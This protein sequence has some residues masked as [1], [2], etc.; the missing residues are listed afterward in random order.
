MPQSLAMVLVHI[1]FSTKERVPCIVREVRP[2]LNAYLAGI[3]RNL[4]CIP[5]EVNSMVDHVHIFCNL[6]RTVAVASLVEEFKKGSS[7]WI[8]PK[9]GAVMRNFHWQGG[10]GA[11]SVS[12]SMVPRVRR[13]ILDQEGHHQKVTF[14]E[15]FRAFLERH[16]ERH[17]VAYD[18]RYVWD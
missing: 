9:G 13:Y 3:L 5:L 15:E 14:Q 7:T 6:A 4:R 8:K 2:G 18:E 17:G 16:G 10:Y 12:P 11:F 1:I